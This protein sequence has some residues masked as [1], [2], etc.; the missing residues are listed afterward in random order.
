MDLNF[1]YCRSCFLPSI[2]CRNLSTSFVDRIRAEL[3]TIDNYE[4]VNLICSKLLSICHQI[5]DKLL[6]G[7]SCSALAR[8]SRRTVHAEEI[9]TD[10]LPQAHKRKLQRKNSRCLS[11]YLTDHASKLSLF[12]SMPNCNIQSPASSLWACQTRR[13]CRSR[14]RTDIESIVLR[15]RPLNKWTDIQRRRKTVCPAKKWIVEGR[16]STSDRSCF[17]LTFANNLAYTVE[18]ESQDNVMYDELREHK[19]IFLV[20][21]HVLPHFDGQRPLIIMYRVV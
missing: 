18:S 11:Q 3:G 6:T 17:W 2:R 20:H 1:I 5:A 4:P 15:M 12:W 21:P 7:K 10:Y 16:T 8:I 19:L 13:V 9:C 14:I